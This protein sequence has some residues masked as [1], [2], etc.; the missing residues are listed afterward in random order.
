MVSG[1]E[2]LQ[3]KNSNGH[4]R[5]SDSHLEAIAS[6]LEVLNSVFVFLC[7]NFSDFF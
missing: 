3:Q 6:D 7:S 2:V 1:G 5:G 4:A